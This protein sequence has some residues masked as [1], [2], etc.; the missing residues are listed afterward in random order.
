MDS[1]VDYR[2]ISEE[3][4]KGLTYLTPNNREN[5]QKFEAI[6]KKVCKSSESYIMNILFD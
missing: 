3:K 2:G 5:L 1:F 4:L 6:Y